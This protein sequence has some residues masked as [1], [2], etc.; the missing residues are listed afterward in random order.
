MTALAFVDA[1]NKGS[2]YSN[3]FNY[4]HSKEGFRVLALGTQKRVLPYLGDVRDHPRH[5][6]AGLHRRYLASC[7]EGMHLDWVE[8]HDPLA[9]FLCC[10]GHPHVSSFFG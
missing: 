7:R 6:L 10:F 8:A 2:P 4:T 1:T 3:L 9:D 5:G